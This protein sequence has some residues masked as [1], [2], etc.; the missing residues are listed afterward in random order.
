MNVGQ[1]TYA[2]KVMEYMIL[3][4]VKADRL[5]L[6]SDMQCYADTGWAHQTSIHER[7]KQYRAR[8]N[9][10]LRVY[11][12]DLA[13]YGSAQFPQRD[14]NTALLAGWSDRIIELIATLERSED[15]LKEIESRSLLAAPAGEPEGATT[16]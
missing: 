8:I 3:E 14:L 7:V 12:V 15:L 11:S 4:Q 16:E 9:P 10:M 6:F 5:V 2:H 13:G 1:A